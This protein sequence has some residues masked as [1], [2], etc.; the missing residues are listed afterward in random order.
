[1]ENALFICI[2]IAIGMEIIAV[3]ATVTIKI[4]SIIMKKKNKQ[5]ITEKEEKKIKA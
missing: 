3:L 5:V 1:L 4:V 2:I